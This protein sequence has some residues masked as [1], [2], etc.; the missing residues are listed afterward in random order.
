MAPSDMHNRIDVQNPLIYF[1]SGPGAILAG[2]AARER[3]AAIAV[4]A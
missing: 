4:H 2:E 3:R 1:R